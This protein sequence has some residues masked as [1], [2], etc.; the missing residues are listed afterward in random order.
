M[1]PLAQTLL[2][3]KQHMIIAANAAGVMPFGF[4]ASVADYS[5]TEAFKAMVERSRAFGFMGA[6]CIHPNQVAVV[7]KAYKPAAT[8]AAYARAVVDRYLQAQNEG[9]ASFAIEGKMVDIPVVE[10]AERLLA[11]VSAVEAREARMQAALQA[12]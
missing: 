2:S 7:N 9:R 5:D 8:E 10:R 6:G 4:I 11:R 12:L 3:P 1:E